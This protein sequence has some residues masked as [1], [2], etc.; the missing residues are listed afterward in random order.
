MDVFVYGTL[1]DPERVE[2]VLAEY[3]FG[4]EMVLRGL[5]H[6]DGTYPTLAPG[7]QVAGRLLK[8]PEIERL[9]R[10]EG[11]E[12]GLYV[13]VAVPVENKGDGARTEG[14]NEEGSNG[15]DE[16]RTVAVYVGDPA[17]LGLNSEIEWPGDGS[18]AERVERYARDR[19]VR[20]QH[21]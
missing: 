17:A 6:V 9:D 16:R 14:P 1:T 13:R 18:F 10:Y 20:V 5:Y 4:G 12:R 15:S 2:G 8:T 19:S 7:G 3:A 21:A 11:V